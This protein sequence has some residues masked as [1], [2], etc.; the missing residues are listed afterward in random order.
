MQ[1]IKNYCLFAIKGMNQEAFF[2]QL[3]KICL[4]Y[5][6]NRYEKNKVSFKVHLKYYKTVKKL[7]INSGFEILGQRKRGLFYRLFDLKKNIGV[8]CGI[9][10]FTIF[11]LVQFPIVWKVK[12]V[13]VSENIGN[14]ISSYVKMNFPMR[15]NQ[16]NCK[17][18]E[19]NLRQKF[20]HLSF[21]SVALIGQTLVI[22]SKESVEPDEKNGKFEPIFADRDCKITKIKLIQGTLAVEEGDSVQTGD[23]IVFPYIIDSYGE[24]KKVKPKAEITIEYWLSSSVLHS[25]EEYVLV[26]TGNYFIQ[27]KLY[28]FGLELYSYNANNKYE[29]YII[30][31]NETFFSKNNIL[32]FVYKKNIY[33]ET[34][35]V[36]KKEKYED[37]REKK[38]MQAREKALQN[39]SKCDI[40]KNE[41]YLENCNNQIFEISYHVTMEKEIVIK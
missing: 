8:Y 26:K 14:E 40:I 5:D 22:N 9:A 35:Y 19:I 32:P 6:I 2:N 16:L 24:E 7:I 41:R 29:N 38:I 37:V 25:N 20:D 3:R 4:V 15:K 36:L 30:E 1:K 23:I 18:I 34:H 39:A 17:N 13:G 12:V 11:Y 28:L 27:N 31:E 21:V 10:I 33:Y